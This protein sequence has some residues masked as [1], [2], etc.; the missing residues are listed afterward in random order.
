MEGFKV[1]DNDRKLYTCSKGYFDNFDEE[2]EFVINQ[3]GK[4]LMVTTLEDPSGDILMDIRYAPSKYATV[5]YTGMRDSNCSKIYNGSIVRYAYI[6]SHHYNDND[7]LEISDDEWSTAEVV[8]CG[9][10][11]YPAFDLKTHAFDCNALAYIKQSGKY[12]IEVVGCVYT[13][14]HL[15]KI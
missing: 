1:W 11:D 6:N 2:I 7:E 8:W 4:L 15:V 10:S 14:P 12:Q 5:K 9:N 13:T 3:N